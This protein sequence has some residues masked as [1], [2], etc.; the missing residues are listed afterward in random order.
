MVQRLV[1]IALCS[2]LAAFLLVP[3]ASA[4]SYRIVTSNGWITRLGPLHLNDPSLGHAISVFGQPS[5]IKPNGGPDACRV[6]WPGRRIAATFANFGGS[7]A[8]TLSGGMLQAL[9]IR[10]RA[11]RTIGGLRVG[12]STSRLHRLYPDAELRSGVWELVTA[13]FGDTP[14]ATISALPRNGRVAALKLWVG[15]A[16]D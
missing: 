9:T 2:A 1:T 3:T 12:H 14:V 5:S 4:R 11:W 7:N 8:C 6:K 15:G 10:S 16:G 13:E